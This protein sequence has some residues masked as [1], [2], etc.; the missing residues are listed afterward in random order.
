MN[1][2][3][4]SLPADGAYEILRARLNQAAQSLS[5]QLA[6]L[7]QARSETFGSTQWEVIGRT[8]IR[9]SNNCVPRDIKEF[10][11]YLLFGYNVFVGLRSEIHI[12]DVFSL[13]RIEQKEKSLEIIEVA[14]DDNI[15]HHPAFVADFKEL[16]RYYKDARLNQLRALPGGKRLMVFQTGRSLKDLKVFRWNVSENQVRYID[17]RGERD[18][19]Y[20]PSHDFEWR[21]T[22]RENHI[23]GLHPHVSILDQIFVETIG[24]DVTVKIENNTET[25][26]GIYCEPVE[27]PDQ[28]LADGQIFYAQIGSL[29]VLKIRPYREQA[30]R[31]LVYNPRRQEVKRMDAIGAACLR[32]PE[33][34][35]L[36]FPGGYYLIS[37]DY[38]QFEDVE[39][40]QYRA[41]T[42]KRLIRAPNGED[43]LYVFHQEE[44]GTQVLYAYNLIRKEVQTPLICH[45]FS[46]LEDGRMVVF[47]AEN[48]TPGKV[49]PMQIWQTP[50]YSDEFAAAQP[51]GESFL[52]RVG[53]VELVRGISDGYSLKRML[54]EPQPTRVMYEDLIRNTRRILDTYHWLHLIDA[55]NLAATCHAILDHAEHI[56]DEFEKVQALQQQAG[57]ALHQAQQAHQSL[58]DEIAKQSFWQHISDYVTHLAA[59]RSQRGQLIGLKE[60]RYINLSQ[61]AAL[62]ST[63][64]EE[65]HQLSQALLRFL[66]EHDAL[67]SYHQQLDTQL[68]A[69]AAYTT[70]QETSAASEALDQTRAGL[71][72]LTQI[73]NELQMDDATARTH[74]LESI[75]EVYAKLNRAN[76]ELA[77]KRKSLLSGWSQAEFAAQFKLFSQSVSAALAQAD[78]PQKADE[79]LSR[80]LV[81][82]EELESRFSEF[83]EFVA[84]WAEKREEVYTALEAR[85]QHLVEERQKRALHLAQAAQRILR[86]IGHRAASFQNADEQNAYFAADAMVLKVRDLIA[87]LEALGD[88]VKAGDLAG[89]LKA[90]RDQAGR[91]LR[92]RSEIYA[93]GG[94]QIQLGQHQFS[95]NTQA[96]DLTLLP[97]QAPNGE[98]QLTLHL[99]GTD[100]FEPLQDP[101]LNALRDYWEQALVSES[102][103]MYRGEFLAGSLLLQAEQDPAFAEQLYQ[104][105]RSGQL[106]DVVRQQA[107]QRYDQGYERGVHDSDA[108]QILDALLRLNESAALL[109]YSPQCRALAQWF[110]AEYPDEQQCQRWAQQARTLQKLQ[111]TFGKENTAYAQRLQQQLAQAIGA[112]QSTTPLTCSPLNAAQYLCAE[113][114]QGETFTASGEASRLVEAFLHYLEQRGERVAFIHHVASNANDS[115]NQYALAHAWLSAFAAQYQPPVDGRFLPEAAVMLLT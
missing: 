97:K 51:T 79:Q 13:H 30:W 73:I 75:A 57:Q 81:Q 5:E 39:Q 32:L 115:A 68:A 92:D 78:T 108:T 91:E 14:E 22:T 42:F 107:A 69:I 82:L 44:Q 56:I 45:G 43:V 35:G 89:Q 112:F 66:L 93:A 26:E 64:E 71:D 99:T 87:K 12:S 53:N 54:D 50:F 17:N 20:P 60:Q 3:H 94:T 104:A 34:H 95:V 41:L 19:V 49:H 76:A 11:P 33:D 113:L 18:N 61:V 47:R 84:Q 9:T 25:G 109:R 100:F 23:Q 36:I 85:K 2:E 106:A 101:Q 102:E 114:Q 90:A 63:I 10:G 21:A 29:I 16:Y 110:W 67:Q 31:Y 24:G 70:S 6:A 59:L 40:A 7:N 111:Q 72:L 4:T 83:D 55:G 37:G 65:F 48:D 80:L 46:L 28:S 88:S 98:L 8:R 58:H 86:T 96:L 74:I 62:E 77:L 103:A 52:A 1:D 15:L 105:Q 38:K 27:D